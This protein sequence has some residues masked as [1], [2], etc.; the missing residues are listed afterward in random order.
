MFFITPLR[1]LSLEDAA[2]VIMKAILL[3]PGQSR[4][5]AIS[6]FKSK[7]RRL[8]DIANVLHSINVIEKV[9]IVHTRR[10]AFRWSGAGIF[11]VH[12][13]VPES[14]ANLDV[15]KSELQFRSAAD[16]EKDNEG[17]VNNVK[18]EQDQQLQPQS[19]TQSHIDTVMKS[20]T[21]SSN[22][23]SAT[24]A[25]AGIG[26][27]STQVNWASK[28]PGARV[29][30]HESSVGLR[31]AYNNMY[32]IPNLASITNIKS[33]EDADRSEHE[34]AVASSIAF[35][36]LSSTAYTMLPCSTAVDFASLRY[37]R[38]YR[39][40]TSKFASLYKEA[41]N[42]WIHTSHR[43]YAEKAE[44]DRFNRIASHNIMVGGDD[45]DEYWDD[46]LSYMLCVFDMSVAYNVSM[47]I[48]VKNYHEIV[49]N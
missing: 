12:S 5:Q 29:S 17:A 48:R 6:S 23:A 47:P 31:A 16:R 10:S 41:A 45:D 30:D 15:P 46:M 19:I 43:V 18:E 11:Q 35:H 49:Y 28:P 25:G 3:R 7:V 13:S 21:Q 14:Y 2:N 34:S 20:E 40:S 37:A 4:E 9:H 22:N 38:G 8:Y 27:G 42:H 36:N 32:N 39:P 24:G 1:I 44:D 26:N 33:E